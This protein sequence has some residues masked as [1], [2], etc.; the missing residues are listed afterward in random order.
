MSKTLD[1]SVQLFDESGDELWRHELPQLVADSL[2]G[3]CGGRLAQGATISVPV[4]AGD[5]LVV[6]TDT[7]VSVTVD[8]SVFDVK[9]FAIIDG[10]F[11][12]VS[13]TTSSTYNPPLVR[14]FSATKEA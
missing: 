4:P 2:V 7:P 11:S 13:I 9:D 1:M 5:L 3:H 8:S 14:V 12:A 10:D 6:L